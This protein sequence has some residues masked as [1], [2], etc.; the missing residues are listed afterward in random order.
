MVHAI[1]R[2]AFAEHQGTLPVDS[3]AHTESVDDVRAVMERGGAILC[4]LDDIAVGSARFT[5]EPSELYVGRV[6]VLPT[7]RRRGIASEMMRYLEAHAA[8]LGKSA[9]RIGVRD[10]LPSNVGLYQSLGYE[11]V[12]VNPHPRGADRVWTMSKRV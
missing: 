12:S 8:A 5:V 7:H 9:V 3:G 10:S 1:M 2:A 4:F 6:A 11:V